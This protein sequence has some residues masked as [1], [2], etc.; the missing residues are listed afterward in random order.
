MQ[1]SNS[2]EKIKNYLEGLTKE[3]LVSLILKLAPQNF[4]EA[5]HAQLASQNEAKA[6]FNKV[7]EAI[8][9]ILADDELLYN[10]SEF[11]NELLEQ[12]E[13]LRGLWDKLPLEIGDLILR[14]VRDIEQAF[15]EGYL[16][17]ENYGKED[18]YFES[19]SLNDYIFRFASNLPSDIK[20]GYVEELRVVLENFG[21]S[22]F[23]SI[24]EK[25]TDS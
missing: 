22:T 15:E 23:L 7:V 20:P 14:I 16:Y 5:I 24:E 12:L 1:S 13:K 3:E 18:N 25:L 11:E 8:D 6:I 21:F 17:I 2:T 19:E 9:T 4:F 10:P